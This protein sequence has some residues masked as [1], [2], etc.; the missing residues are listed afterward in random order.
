MTTF[1]V[2]PTDV[3]RIPAPRDPPNERLEPPQASVREVVA[4]G[5]LPVARGGD[6]VDVL[7][8][9][10]LTDAVVDQ[11]RLDSD[12]RWVRIEQ[13]S[14]NQFDERLAIQLREELLYEISESLADTQPDRSAKTGLTRWQYVLPIAGLVLAVLGL[15]LAPEF[16]VVL[17]LTGAAVAFSATIAFRVF[18]VGLWPLKRVRNRLREHYA[19]YRGRHSVDYLA[20]RAR[21]AD[22]AL[23]PLADADLP[24]YTILVPAFHEANVITA[25]I[26]NLERLDYPRDRMEVLVL[27]EED[28]VD[29]IE[30]ARAAEPPSYMRILIVPR[31]QPQTKPRACNYGLIFARGELVVIYD[32][33]DRPE[34]DQLRRVVT[35]FRRARSAADAGSAGA[36]LACVQCSLS[37]FNAP[38]NVLTR[39]FAIEYAYLFDAMLPGIDGTGIPIPLGGTSNHFDAAMLRRLGGWDPYNVTEDADLGIRAAASGYRVGVNTSTTW[40]EA[41]S[42]TG[43]FIKQRTRWIKG[44]MLTAAVNFR[45]PVQFGRA[46]G[47]RGMVCLLALILGTPAAFLVYPVMMLFALVTVA[48]EKWGFLS[49]PGWL[50]TVGIVTMIAG[51]GV[52][53]LLSGLVAVPRYGWRIAGFAVFF[54]VYWLLHSVAAWRAAWQTIFTPHVWE[55]TPHGLSDDF[56]EEQ[57]VG[58]PLGSV[59]VQP[60]V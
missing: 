26:G 9:R 33:E 12:A 29:T 37:Y 51:T 55:K 21:H 16:T 3:P 38:Y 24:F 53:I 41:C 27:L 18:C 13:V 46:T 2:D 19:A 20:Y 5:W 50:D 58:Q 23:T 39:L 42:Q 17:G 44:Y 48:G 7:A 36:P 60:A 35:D 49:L 1:T 47:L 25:L 56:E 4:R 28:D 43:A 57:M 11:I 22:S 6:T 31:G 52:T 34:S 10:E 14:P 8:S 15:I 30:A 45:H 40:E 59:I 54:P 32:A